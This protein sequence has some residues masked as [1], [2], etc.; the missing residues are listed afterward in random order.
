VDV[1]GGSDARAV[2][3]T[4]AVGVRAEAEVDN[5]GSRARV[6]KTAEL[7]R[8][9]DTPKE[10]TMPDVRVRMRVRANNLV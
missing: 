8:N 5:L 7:A 10:S 2:L 6:E 1:D 4:R 3:D 9:V